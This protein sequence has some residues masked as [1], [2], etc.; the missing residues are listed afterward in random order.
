MGV[1]LFSI[2]GVESAIKLVNEILLEEGYGAA[3]VEGN[4]P[5]AAA[6]VA[7]SE[8]D[9]S[10]EAVDDVAPLSMKPKVRCFCITI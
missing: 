1:F 7:E 6:A 5:P 10:D 8:T 9:S 4:A 2:E 3:H